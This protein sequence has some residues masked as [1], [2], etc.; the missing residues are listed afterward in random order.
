[1]F[2]DQVSSVAVVWG[3]GMYGGMEHHPHWHVAVDAMDD[4]E[5]HA[6]EAAHGW[7]GDGVRI[8]CWED[9]VLS[10]GTVS[11]L[12]ARAIGQVNGVAAEAAVW[13]GYQD[14]LDAERA[15]GGDRVSWPDS[16]GRVDILRD[17]LFSNLPYMEGAFFYKA[18][19]DAVGADVLDGV[20][21]RFYLAHQGRAAGMQDMLDAIETDTGFD[22]SALVR[23]WLR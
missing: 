1:M 13:A 3:E 11:Y 2:G 23:Q 14:E 21:S 15:D 5:T 10:E 9:F 18:V 4:A 22:P 19:A 20:I 6:H 8:R 12:T 7:F 16:C 17:G